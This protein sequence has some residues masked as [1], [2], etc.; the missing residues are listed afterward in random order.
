ME[1]SFCG[2]VAT[3]ICSKCK[4]VAYCSVE[5]QRLHWSTHKKNCKKKH[6]EAKVSDDPWSSSGGA[7]STSESQTN[8]EKI[9]KSCRCMF[10][11][12]ELLLSS[13]DEAV[14][15]MEVCPALQEQL[16]DT[17]QFTLPES[18]RPTTGK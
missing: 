2:V 7:N 1:C 12:E 15:H 9:T 5:H 14:Q 10:C 11:G 16:N 18:I 4:T 17:R 3:Q 13:E 8:P 6:N